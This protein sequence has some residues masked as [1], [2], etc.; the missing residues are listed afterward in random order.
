MLQWWR[1][2]QVVE[3]IHTLCCSLV[4]RYRFCCKALLLQ[5]NVMPARGGNADVVGHTAGQRLYRTGRTH[6]S[7]I[8]S[9]R[10]ASLQRC[11]KSVSCAVGEDEWPPVSEPPKAKRLLFAFK[12]FWFATSAS[13]TLFTAI[14][15]NCLMLA[16]LRSGV[17][18]KSSVF[19]TDRSS[20]CLLACF[21]Y[22]CNVCACLPES[23]CSVV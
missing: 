6:L 4:P 7:H 9:N 5:R 12:T 17:V 19:H 3:A 16:K 10:T 20:R 14:A 22:V 8:L 21:R 2:G 23:F 1:Q 18:S 13:F 15:L 11:P